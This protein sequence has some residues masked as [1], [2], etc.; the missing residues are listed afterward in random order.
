MKILTLSALTIYLSIGNTF[1]QKFDLGSWNILNVKYAVNS[2]WSVFGE[3]QL[4]SLK[5]YDDFHYYEYKGGLNF[6][7]HKNLALSIGTGSYQT[8]KEGGDFVVPKNND[9]FR[10][11]PQMVVYQSIGKLKIEQRYRAEFRFTSNG[12]RNRFRYRLGLSYPFGKENKDYK[13]FQIS[14]TNELFFTDNEPYFERNRLVLA[15]NYKPSKTTTLQL[16]YLH[17]FD[18][19]INDET[20]RDFLQI[21]YFIEIFRKQTTN[22]TA[23]TDIKD[24]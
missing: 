20:G 1:A 22:N 13:P 10:I 4:R 7:A 16:G 11:W 23:D 6:K 21:G 17:Q 24:N 5:F 8:Y 3:A 14:A 12:Y 18:Y 2:K 9:E 19:K 15:L